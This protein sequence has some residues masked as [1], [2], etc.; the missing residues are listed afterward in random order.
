[1]LLGCGDINAHRIL[2]ERSVQKRLFEI[3]RTLDDNTAMEDLEF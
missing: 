2:V 3:P 1:M